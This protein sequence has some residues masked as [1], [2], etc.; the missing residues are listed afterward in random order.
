VSGVMSVSSILHLIS[1]SDF[2]MLIFAHMYSNFFLQM[3]PSVAI[4]FTVY[5]AMKAWLHVPPR[6]KGSRT[7]VAVT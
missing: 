3:V 5:D 2:N 7:A 1:I 4:G 6:E